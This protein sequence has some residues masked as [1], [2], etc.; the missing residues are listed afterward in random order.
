MK[1]IVQAFV[2]SRLDYCN[3]LCYGITD[4]LTHCLQ[5]VQNTAVRIV[6]G[7]SQCDHISPVLRQLHWLP[8]G[9]RVM[10][11][12]AT[13]VHR[14]TSPCPVMPQD[15]WPTIVI[16]LLTPVSDNCVL[17]TFEH[18]LS[19]GHAAVLETGPL[20]P[21]HHKSGTV[22]RAISDCVGCHTASSGGN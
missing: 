9:Q 12:I 4:E 11:K 15:T 22:C 6:T 3:A 7:S 14:S 16:S 18:S 21:Q 1:M 13:L 17:L 10:F 8:V 19:V 20:P 5:S 2:I